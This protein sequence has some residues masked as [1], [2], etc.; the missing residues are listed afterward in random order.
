MTWVPRLRAKSGLTQPVPLGLHLSKNLE[1]LWELCAAGLLR[2]ASGVRGGEGVG[3]VGSAPSGSATAPGA[4]GRNVLPRWAGVPSWAARGLLA[5]G[6]VGLGP[7]AQHGECSRAVTSLLGDLLQGLPVSGSQLGLQQGWGP[8][9]AQRPIGGCKTVSTAWTA[10]VQIYRL[11]W[12]PGTNCCECRGCPAPG[13]GGGADP[14]Q[15][16][17]RPTRASP[18]TG[19]AE[20]RGAHVGG[21]F[22]TWVPQPP[23]G[24]P[25]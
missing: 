18:H 15:P 22:S 23:Q 9:R 14:W 7:L 8:G 20:V 4:T 2:G 13:G 24:T 1:S 12:P 16:A 3:R 10:H 11:V 17:P 21:L 6:R 5:G 19:A 25:S